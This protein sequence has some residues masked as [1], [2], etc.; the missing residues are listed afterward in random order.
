MQAL[1]VSGWTGCGLCS[2]PGSYLRNCN[3]AAHFTTGW[4]IAIQ[5][6]P[7][8]AAQIRFRSHKENLKW[9]ANLLDHVRMSTNHSAKLEECDSAW[10][11]KIW[12]SSRRINYQLRIAGNRPN[13]NR[14][15][16][17]D[18]RIPHASPLYNT[19]SLHKSRSAW[20]P[21]RNGS[22]QCS[23]LKMATTRSKGSARLAASLSSSTGLK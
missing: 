7:H 11:R 23:F 6:S 13:F 10:V 21:G 9:K 12:I 16:R 4:P 22:I 8:Q 17:R 1:G 20:F 3:L 18:F 19:F 5:P 15:R 2:S 14:W